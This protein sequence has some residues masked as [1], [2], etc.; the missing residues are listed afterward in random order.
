MATSFRTIFNSL[1]TNLPAISRY[2]VPSTTIRSSGKN[3]RLLS[4]HTTRTA[5]KTTYPTILHCRGNVFTELLPSNDSG[6][7]RQTLLR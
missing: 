7:H 5:Q 3:Y 1:F 2:T 4:F 6:I